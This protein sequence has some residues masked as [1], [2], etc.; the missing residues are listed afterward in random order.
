MNNKGFS[1]VQVIVSGTIA[2]VLFGV[3]LPFAIQVAGKTQRMSEV[4]EAEQIAQL[5]QLMAIEQ[6][7]SSDDVLGSAEGD[8]CVVNWQKDEMMQAF[9]MDEDDLPK[10]LVEEGNAWNI[11]Y[12][13]ET[14]MVETI[15]LVEMD[16]NGDVVSQV[17]MFP[18]Y[19]EYVR[20]N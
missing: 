1:I 7:G 19:V 9:G 12:D 15:L 16:A 13:A 17:E 6:S 20:A 8:V 18:G 4:Y 14:G 11:H 10:S 5:F 3:I 2:V